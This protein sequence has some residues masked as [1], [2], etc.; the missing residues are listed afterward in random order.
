LRKITLEKKRTA[1][2]KQEERAQNCK[3]KTNICMQKLCC[4]RDDIKEFNMSKG[5]F[6]TTKQICC[7]RMLRARRE[8]N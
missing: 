3:I 4:F 8:A 6:P 7:W 2:I 5:I 1:L